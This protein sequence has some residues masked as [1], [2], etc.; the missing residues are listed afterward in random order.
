MLFLASVA[1]ELLCGEFRAIFA[2]LDNLFTMYLSLILWNFTVD[3]TFVL[4]T[5]AVASYKKGM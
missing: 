1:S 5:F 4:H 3:T 2:H